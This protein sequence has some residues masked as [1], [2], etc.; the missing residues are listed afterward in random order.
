MVDEADLLALIEDMDTVPAP[1]VTP[2]PE[3]P[4]TSEP[5]PEPEPEQK[6]GASGLVIFLVL[7]LAAGGGTFYYFKVLKPKQA[8]QGGTELDELDEL[9]FEGDGFMGMDADEPEQED[10]E[11]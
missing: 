2:E 6:G 7:A 11:E 5:D 8:V 9:D 3:Q 1:V 4:P 10:G